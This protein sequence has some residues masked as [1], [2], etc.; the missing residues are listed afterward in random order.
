M[1]EKKEQ[2]ED[3]KA[4]DYIYNLLQEVG[5]EDK[6][7]FD[8]HIFAVLLDN[9][10]REFFRDNDGLCS[11]TATIKDA[12]R[13]LRDNERRLDDALDRMNKIWVEQLC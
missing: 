11:L 3:V 4:R 9:V 8:R 6:S 5:N 13:Q 7:Y 10:A 1:S 2:T 12:T